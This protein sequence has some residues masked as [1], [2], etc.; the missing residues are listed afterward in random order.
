M[1]VADL[2]SRPVHTVAPNLSAEAARAEMR[3][4]DVRHLVV[5]TDGRITGVIS[6]HDLGG[7]RG[8]VPGLEW[9]ADDLSNSRVVVAAPEMSL[10]RA[11]ALLREHRIGCLPVVDGKQLV[12]VITTWDLLGHLAG[13]PRHRARA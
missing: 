6:E 1:R 4:H 13:Q 7:A 9:T 3:R 8:L 2:M 12:G 11:A 10:G 5:M